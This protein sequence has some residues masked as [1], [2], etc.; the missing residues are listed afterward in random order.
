[1]RRVN[2]PLGARSYDIFI[3]PGLLAGLGARC[4]RLG[5]ADRCA[6]I[7]D[8]QVGPRFADAAADSLRAAGFE[9]VTVTIPAGEKSKRLREV[10]RCYDALAAHR[11]ERKSF[12]VALGGGVVGDLAGF[13]AATYLRGLAFV[14]VPTT[15][16]AQ[17]DSSVGGKVGVN[18]PAGKNLVGSFH[19]PRLVLCDLDTLR[20]LPEREFR[21]GLAEVIK[22]GIIAD[23]A[24]FRRLE[25][26][27]D[28]L[29]ARDP[30]ALA[31]TIARCCELKAE[32]VAED[33]TEAGRRAILNFGHTVGHAIEAVT[34]YGK[35]LHGEAISLGQVAAAW[36]S[37]QLAGLPEADVTRIRR[38]LERAGLPVTRRFSAPQRTRLLDA[39]R[40]DKKVS[41]GEALFVLAPRIGDTVWKQRV[42]TGLVHAALKAVAG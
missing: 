30:A 21:A 28:R 24:L 7:T 11:L 42:P 29:L 17:V 23:A 38:L 9:P 32:V 2:V 41:G 40:L 34:A 33:E 16:L 12:V 22:Y 5:F 37:A 15:L 10:A 6:M 27:L 18:L 36:L 8:S 35:F 26:N 39:M 3:G 4:R 14:Q 1:M 31:A 25:R 19:Q 20:T 13:V